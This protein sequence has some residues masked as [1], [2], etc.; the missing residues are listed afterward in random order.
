MRV[1]RTF[2]R[3]PLRGPEQIGQKSGKMLTDP[4]MIQLRCGTPALIL[5]PMDGVTDAPMRALLT[6]RG[7]FSFC[8]SEFF[9]ISQDVPYARTIAQQVPELKSG[10]LTASGVPVQVQFLGGDPDKIGE[11]AL[12]ACSVGAPAID[13]N[14]GCPAPTVN[15]NDGGATLLKFPHRIRDIVAG[16]RKA[17]PKEVAVSA[18]LRLGWDQMDAIH[19]NADMAA[20]GGASWI[21]IHGRTKIQGYTAPAYWGPIG[22]VRQRLNIPVVANGEIWSL[23]DFRRCR[24]ETHCEHFMLGRGALADPSLVHHLAHE[25][26]LPAP[27]PQ[28]IDWPAIFAR[29]VVLCEPYADN[30]Q[31]ALCRIK[32]WLRMADYSHRL[33]WSAPLKRTQSLAEFFKSLSAIAQL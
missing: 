25:L 30:P 16:V 13:L 8:V 14:F 22:E 11:A 28:T 23:D 33:A 26:G 15:R 6:E 4:A 1:A 24:D 5:A 10:G 20:Q 29:F 9:R 19:Q 17:V 7:G 32:Q 12:R 27:V 31:Y 21:T 2:T 18:K 3:A